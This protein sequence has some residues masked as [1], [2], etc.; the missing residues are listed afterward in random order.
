VARIRLFSQFC[1]FLLLF[2]LMTAHLVLGLSPLVLW[3]IGGSLRTKK[4]IYDWYSLSN[5]LFSRLWFCTR[6][7]CRLFRSRDPFT[8]N[9]IID[10]LTL[11]VLRGF[12]GIGGSATIPSAVSPSDMFL[13]RKVLTF[14]ARYLSTC[15]PSVKSA[16]NSVRYFCSGCSCG[17]RIWHDHRRRSNSTYLV[18]HAY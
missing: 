9:V 13:M 4:G 11:A 12:Q 15:V 18:R 8:H 5:C 17:R 1:K 14:S 6:C 3:K 2:L 10:G 16:L 7:A